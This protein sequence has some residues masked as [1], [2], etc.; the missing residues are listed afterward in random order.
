MGAHTPVAVGI[1]TN[2]ARKMPTGSYIAFQFARDAVT[3]LAKKLASIRRA[4][5]EEFQA[6]SREFGPVH[7]LPDLYIAPDLQSHTPS[8][9]GV[10]FRR[11]AVTIPALTAIEK[12]FS[13]RR[14]IE[15]RS[16]DRLFVLG[17]AGMGKTSLLVM[18]RLLELA[19]FFPPAYKTLLLKADAN[20]IPRL[21]A[22]ADPGHTIALVD[23]IDEDPSARTNPL[24]RLSDLIFAVRGFYKVIFT[25]RTQ[26]LP[27]G[28]IE[29]SGS[30]RVDSLYCQLA[31]LAP[32][33]DDQVE[34]Y[35]VKRFG[36]KGLGGLLLSKSTPLLGSARKIASK[37][38][39]LVSRPLLLSYMDELVNAGS[40]RSSAEAYWAMVQRWLARENT[41]SPVFDAHLALIACQE[42]AI[43]LCLRESAF[44]TRGEFAAFQNAC[45]AAQTLGGHEFSTRTLLNVTTDGDYRFAHLSIQEFLAAIW[46][47]SRSSRNMAREPIVLR[48]SSLVYQFVGEVSNSE[49]CRAEARIPFEGV[50]ILGP[51]VQYLSRRYRLP[52]A[53]DSSGDLEVLAVVRKS[54]HESA[55]ASDSDGILCE[56]AE[57]MA[58]GDACVLARL[59][60]IQSAIH[61]DFSAL[62]LFDVEFHA[63]NMRASKWRYC[64][65]FRVRIVE[66]DLSH[67][68]FRDCWFIEC[69]FSAIAP[70]CLESAFFINSMFLGCKLGYVAD[71]AR[72][73][74]VVP[75]WD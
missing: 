11:M 12:F 29:S 47:L 51:L 8:E 72:E 19:S 9:Q 30:V 23:A 14:N 28:S 75:V 31:Y 39:S 34:A 37:S 22:V 1:G 64:I 17:D 53:P 21:N 68:V 24:R 44:I 40:I 73:S 67:C 50:E 35:L 27:E 65:F 42:L 60:F 55:R 26:F 62:V 3:R 69:D 61:A 59:R 41:K 6:I 56:V 58:R 15:P 63:M 25:C 13:A 52:P 43:E 32:F 45:P 4:R 48:T 2:S 38:A 7:L 33:S 49:Q 36:R 10:E 71:M 20:T 5:A 46:L 74:G 18:L 66:S 16:D 54:I 70:A 57:F